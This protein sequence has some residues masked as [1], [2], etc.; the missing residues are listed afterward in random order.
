MLRRVGSRVPAYGP[1]NLVVPAE[2]VTVRVEKLL[3]SADVTDAMV[4]LTLMQL[5]GK[6]GD[7]FRDLP[8]SLRSAL[9]RRLQS[10]ETH[11]SLLRLIAEGGQL[12]ADDA[13]LVLGE[14][15]PTGL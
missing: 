4:Q 11:E 10:A 12:E 15:L 9:L 13:G 2:I 14:S 5:S 7:R 1:L 6:T 3:K 8:E